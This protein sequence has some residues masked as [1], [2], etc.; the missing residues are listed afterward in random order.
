M[1][2]AVSFSRCRIVNVLYFREGVFFCT[3]VNLLAYTAS[4]APSEPGNL[5]TD[6]LESATRLSGLHNFQGT[7]KF[8]S[9]KVNI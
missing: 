7:F 9:I 4:H 8:W 3:T 5:L 1:Y 6:L 2:F